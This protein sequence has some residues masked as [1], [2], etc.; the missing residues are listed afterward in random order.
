[1]K[2]FSSSQ[3]DVFRAARKLPALLLF[4]TIMALFKPLPGL[5]A[6]GPCDIPNTCVV[7]GPV[8]S[9]TC[10]NKI[11]GANF[12]SLI[13]E[14]LL[15]PP[16]LALTTPQ[17]LIIRG[18]LTCD[19]NYTF[20][21]GSELVFVDISSGI[22]IV[23]F[24]GKLTISGS[25]LH[26]CNQ[27]WRGLRLDG[28]LA[29]NQVGSLR[30]SGSASNPQIIR[31]AFIGVEAV[32]GRFDCI[33]NSFKGNVFSI[34]IAGK[35]FSK[36]I[37]GNDIDGSEPLLQPISVGQS[38]FTHPANGILV[39]YCEQITVG[40]PNMALNRIHDF[41]Q[42]FIGPSGIN[43]PYGMNCY[44]SNVDVYNTIFENIFVD[45]PYDEGYGLTAGSDGGHTVRYFGVGSE[46][47][48]TPSFSR[49]SKS[50][51]FRD[52]NGVIE[53]ARFTD[54][55]R[56]VDLSL[57]TYPATLSIKNNLFEN[58]HTTGVVI[59][60]NLPLKSATVTDNDFVDNSVLD[61]GFFFLG[62]IGLAVGNNQPVPQNQFVIENNE[63]RLNQ[64]VLSTTGL[65]ISKSSK[66]RVLNNNFVNQSTASSKGIQLFEMSNANNFI[67]NILTDKTTSSVSIGFSVFKAGKNSFCSNQMYYF[68]TGINFEGAEC[69]GTTYFKNEHYT[70]E[71]GLL[72]QPG[73]RIGV[74][75]NR[76]NK[77]PESG[78]LEAAYLGT[79]NTY[80]F[81]R[82][83]VPQAQSTDYWPSPYNPSPWFQTAPA[84]PYEF[85]C[86]LDLPTEPTEAD[87]ALLDADFI[88]YKD[89]PKTEWDASLWL[90]Q[91]LH[92]NPAIRQSGSLEEAFYNAHLNDNI[93]KLARAASSLTASTSM[94]QD[95]SDAWK[96]TM[97]AI[98]TKM[99]NLA[100]LR[101]SLC[102][103]EE[104]D[105]LALINQIDQALS[106]LKE[107]MDIHAGQISR[108]QGA[109]STAL[110]NLSFDLSNITTTDIA[111]QHLKT[112]LTMQTT[113]LANNQEAWTDSEKNT[114]NAIA[115]L[116]RHEYG[117]G[118]D[119]A[120]SALNNPKF[121]DESMCPGYGSGRSQGAVE[122]ADAQQMAVSPNPASDGIWVKWQKTVERGHISLKSIT[123][124][125]VMQL[126]IDQ[127]SDIYLPFNTRLANGM[128]TVE[129]YDDHGRRLAVTKV[130][131]VR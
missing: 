87:L 77:W 95:L 63:F 71:N 97:D 131:I 21:S 52:V 111:E 69:D 40:R 7:N 117:W 46:A 28:V 106:E 108:F 53:N 62:H 121:D 98:I 9:F 38:S 68:N 29:N 43:V 123:G 16:N 75:K 85:I 124:A 27:L 24:T 8:S 109:M 92:E 65:S 22:D 42:T 11:N 26:G 83:L 113:R 104:Q 70:R 19:I 37:V 126:Q 93:G 12:S 110:A 79:D 64:S 14:G 33:G 107:L 122:T 99:D 17:K 4:F 115:E 103:A 120:R 32:G 67:G 105:E 73:T 59:S 6:Q 47:T 13:V 112:V 119:W 25:N 10:I 3:T 100:S 88:R 44:N 36:G 60:G 101:E 78:T 18:L 129:L 45:Y 114:L 80:T 5:L 30:L 81:S 56:M 15:L 57:Y 94:G 31:D 49:V 102:N 35:V 118:V 116:C 66:L 55:T 76:W 2:N 90:Y 61:P 39:Q 96:G 54:G 20:A 48:S 72:L 41:T 34:R 84:P 82:F 130:A 50:I 91:R 23:G 127:Q 89:Y 125:K 1:M 128:Y 58:Y 51:L 86:Y 74:Q